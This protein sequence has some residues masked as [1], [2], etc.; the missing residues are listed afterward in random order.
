I[1]PGLSSV[2]L[3]PFRNGIPIPIFSGVQFFRRLGP[4]GRQ[5]PALYL[6]SF[7]LPAACRGFK[8]ELHRCR[9]ALRT[10]EKPAVPRGNSVCFVSVVWPIAQKR[11]RDGQL[12]LS[13]LPPPPRRGVARLAGL[14]S[15]RIRTQRRD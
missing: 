5:S 8:F 15:G 3:R 7:L 13:V 6:V 12:P 4:A 1:R 2:D 9:S 14:A 10:V 11:Y